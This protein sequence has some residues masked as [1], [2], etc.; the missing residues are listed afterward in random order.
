MSSIASGSAQEQYRGCVSLCTSPAANWYGILYLS[1][2]LQ[3]ENVR[4]IYMVRAQGQ[5]HYT[6]NAGVHPLVIIVLARRRNEAMRSL[7]HT[8]DELI[9]SVIG[10][11]SRCLLSFLCSIALVIG[12]F[13]KLSI[14][15]CYYLTNCP[16]ARTVFAISVDLG[17]VS[18]SLY[19]H[20][21]YLLRAMTRFI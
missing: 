19:V 8:I 11:Y 20:L 16:I 10:L 2:L 3:R 21:S 17:C 5:Q 18:L 13:A 14:A 7:F 12:K 4:V 1:S 15:E 9:S 6:A